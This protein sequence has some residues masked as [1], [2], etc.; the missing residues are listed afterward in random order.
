MEKRQLAEEE[1]KNTILSWVR[2]GKLKE[3]YSGL[4]P[5]VHSQKW[6]LVG[7]WAHSSQNPD[8]AHWCAS[9]ISAV[10]SAAAPHAS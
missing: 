6:E 4:E 5:A 9:Q 1:T 2:G 10:S 7:L 3:G 8:S